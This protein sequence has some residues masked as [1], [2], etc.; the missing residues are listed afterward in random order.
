MFH[1]VIYCTVCVCMKLTASEP[2]DVLDSPIIVPYTWLQASAPKGRCYVLR[3]QPQGVWTMYSPPTHWTASLR[4]RKAINTLT[5]IHHIVWNRLSR[6]PSRL[7]TI[8]RTWSRPR[9]KPKPG[10]AAF[11]RSK[12]APKTYTENLQPRTTKL[13]PRTKTYTETLTRTTTL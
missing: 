6:L 8:R 5:T 12:A 2:P 13:T 1:S 3:H 7:K 9:H 11:T 4:Q 10:P